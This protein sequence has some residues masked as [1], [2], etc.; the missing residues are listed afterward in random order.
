VINRYLESRVRNVQA[1][2][3]AEGLVQHRVYLIAG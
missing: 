1:G 2:P 3:T